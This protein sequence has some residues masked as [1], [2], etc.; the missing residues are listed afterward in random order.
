MAK[1]FNFTYTLGRV[2]GRKC[3]IW[4]AD[5]DVG[6]CITPADWG[7]EEADAMIAADKRGG[8]G[9]GGFIFWFFEGKKIATDDQYCLMSWI[10]WKRSMIR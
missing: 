5:P 1:S 2:C 7:P 3:A 8:G 10:G 6:L 9:S 4:S